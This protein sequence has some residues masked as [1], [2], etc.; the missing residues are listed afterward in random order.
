[1]SAIH[2]IDDKRQMQLLEDHL[3]RHDK[4]SADS[5]RI[6]CQRTAARG[7]SSHTVSA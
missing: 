7:Q 1:M 4:I 2:R 3:Y 6:R 5:L